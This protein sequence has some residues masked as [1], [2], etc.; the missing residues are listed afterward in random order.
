MAACSG[1]I[2]FSC[3]F[4]CFWLGKAM[5]VVCARAGTSAD[6]LKENEREKPHAR[7]ENKK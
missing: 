6:T 4:V 7:R 3:V 2:V 5:K 1:F